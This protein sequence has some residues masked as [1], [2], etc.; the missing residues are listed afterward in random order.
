MPHGAEIR[1]PGDIREPTLSEAEE[2]L[3]LGKKSGIRFSRCLRASLIPKKPESMELDTLEQSTLPISRCT[4][5]TRQSID[6]RS[7][8][9]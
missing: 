8:F 6:I 7:G 9:T 5:Y 1:Y 4:I 2:T 3:E